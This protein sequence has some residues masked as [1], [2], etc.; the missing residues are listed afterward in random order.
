MEVPGLCVHSTVHS[1]VCILDHLFVVLASRQQRKGLAIQSLWH[2]SKVYGIDSKAHTVY[3]RFWVTILPAVIMVSSD[4]E[5]ITL[6]DS[7]VFQAQIEPLFIFNRSTFS[8]YIV[9]ASETKGV[10]E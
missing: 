9:P 4:F 2:V 10:H 5:G 1:C 8:Y 7:T 6:V 3:L